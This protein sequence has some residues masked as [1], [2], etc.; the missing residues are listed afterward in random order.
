MDPYTA[1]SDV[2]RIPCGHIFHTNCIKD[3][4]G[5][6]PNFNCPQCRQYCDPKQIWKTY[7]QEVE[8]ENDF[9]LRM[10]TVNVLI[11]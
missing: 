5:K 3:W 2:G 10:L 9:E 11:C 7:I 6:G 8:I 4:I 1:T